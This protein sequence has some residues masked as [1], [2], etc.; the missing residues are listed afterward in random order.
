LDG[1][2]GAVAVEHVIH[3]AFNIDDKRH[4]HHHK[5]KVFREIVFNEALE[6]KDGLWVSLRVRRLLYSSGRI[7]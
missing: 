2:A 5:V 3:T 7:F 4:G 6:G 1:R